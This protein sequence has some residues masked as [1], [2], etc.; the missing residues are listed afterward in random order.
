MEKDEFTKISLKLIDFV[1]ENFNH[2]QLAAICSALVDVACF[3]YIQQAHQQHFS[4]DEVKKS[5]KNLVENIE[6]R[7]E[8]VDEIMKKFDDYD[9]ESND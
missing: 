8:D 6:N 4:S 1:K 2:H 7:I 3:Y 9:S 5:L